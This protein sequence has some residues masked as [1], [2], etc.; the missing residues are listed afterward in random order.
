VESEKKYK[1]L[2]DNNPVPMFI[3]DTGTLQFID[4]NKEAFVKYGYTREEFLGLTLRDILDPEEVSLYL[5]RSAAGKEAGEIQKHAWKHKKKNGE[6]ILISVS[7]Q[8]TDYNGRPATLVMVTDI[9][10]KFETEELK[11]NIRDSEE[12]RRLIMNAALDAIICIDTR[13]NIIF[14]NPQA[15]KVFGWKEEEVMGKCLSQFIIPEQYRQRHDEGMARYL[16]A[17]EGPALNVLMEFSAINKRGEEFPVELSIMP[18]RQGKEEFFCSFIRDISKRKKTESDIR[19]AYEEKNS[20]LESIDDGFFAV[21]K[22]SLVTYWNRKAEILLGE[23]REEVI[24]RNLH[25]MFA[26][27][28][29]RVFYDNYKKAVRENTTVHFEGFSIRSNKWFAVSA[30]PSDKGLSVY[31]KDVTEQKIAEE[32]LRES[33]FRYRSLIE[34]ATDAI[35][36]ADMKMQIIDVN[37][38]GC[39]LLGYSKEELLQVYLP[40]LFA[41]EEVITNP[42]KLEELRLGKVVRNERKV[43]RKDGSILEVEV[44]GKILEDGRFV[45]FARDITERKLAELQLKETNERYNLISKATND[46]VWDWDLVSGE[47][48]RNKEGWRK[49]F[50]T[51]EKEIET[52]S[53]EEWDNRIHPEDVGKLNRKVEEMHKAEKD[54]FEIELRVL[55]DDG[56]YAYIHDRG[57]IIRNDQGKAV[58]IIGATQDITDRKE[59][60]QQVAKSELR[61]KS[62]VQN[63]SDLLSIMDERGYY[64]YSSP[65]IKK[66][67]GYEP[68]FM[69]GKNAFSFIHPDDVFKI[70]N[71]FRGKNTGGF[72]ELSPYRFRNAEGKWRWLESKMTDMST[73]PEVNGYVFNSR[74][75]TERKTAEEEI[76]KLSIIARETVNAVVIT[77]PGGKILWVNEGFTQ[78]TEFELEEVRGKKPGDILH[79]E[80]TSQ[81]VVRFMR[82]KIR[83]IE[84][85]ECDI[86]NYSKSGRKYWLRLQCQPQFDEA[87]RIKNFFSIQTDITREKEAAEILKA[88]EERYRYLFNNNP[89]CIFIWDLNTLRILEVN[90]TALKQYGYTPDEFLSKTIMNHGTSKYND[91]IKTFIA[92]AQQ[93]PDFTAVYISK[94]FTKAGK[95]IYMNIHSHR[96]RYKGK[97][98][99]LALAS[100]ETEKVFLEKSLEMER[101]ARQKEITAAVISAQE[102]ER[103]EI[104]RELHDNINQILASSRLYLGMIKPV[105]EET[106]PYMGE[107]DNLINTAIQEIRSLSHSMISPSLNESEL[108]EALTHLIKVTGKASPVAI[109]LDATA[110]NEKK[111]SDKLSLTIYRIVQEQFNNILKYAKAKNVLV[112]L[113]QDDENILLRIK[114]DG[115]G[116]DA[117]KKS[118]GVGLMNIRTRASLYSGEL[119]IISSPGKGC[120]LNVTFIN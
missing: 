86:I 25:E 56:T 49:L 102:N 41:D 30:F 106:R 83:N 64:L 11:E 13:G 99:I 53:T 100:N 46:M 115:V 119:A 61:F 114:D 84:P 35:C 72:V 57:N 73:S 96:I 32:K 58:R 68:E 82:Q 44:S 90:D 40:D 54:F 76:E 37:P 70:K 98:A 10:Q 47:V 107:T 80:E 94:H 111:I 92:E 113:S 39:A 60:E 18:I 6:W 8:L 15:E 2:F 118:T 36:I 22:N 16:A 9:T 3:W 105:T 69:I 38:C 1:N 117:T 27:P 120:E 116:F 14:W 62:L 24:G 29:S 50:R 109:T 23:K 78:I 59:A 33:E 43:K 85:F 5:R 51:G 4:C 21:D 74:D 97:D 12:K 19:K 63:S 91:R 112:H 42:I 95:E 55:R 93:T 20:V 79:G 108:V 87:G 17:G 101:N 28:G 75:V 52:G 31:F 89:A 77:D 48:Y 34:Q 81:A 7:E 45:V 66:I 103:Q 104:G 88:S 110:F 65:S 67:L 71:H 26:N